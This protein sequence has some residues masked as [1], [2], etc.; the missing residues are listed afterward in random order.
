[1]PRQKADSC[2]DIVLSND[3]GSHKSVCYGEMCCS[4]VDFKKGT[5]LTPIISQL[6]SGW[7]QVPHW[8]YM[9]KGHVDVKYSDGSKD[10]VKTGDIFYFKPGH[11]AVFAEDSRFVEFSPKDEMVELLDFFKKHM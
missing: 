6:P 9:I 1:M 10:S 3:M 11:T 4:L 2:C 5:D 7:C 8:G